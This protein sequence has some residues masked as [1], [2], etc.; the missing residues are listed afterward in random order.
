MFCRN[1]APEVYPN[2]L[3]HYY[4]ILHYMQNYTVLYY[5]VIYC[6]I[7]YSTVYSKLY[8]VWYSIVY[9]TSITIQYNTVL[10]YTILYY[11]NALHYVMLYYTALYFKVYA[12]LLLVTL[13]MTKRP[14]R[15]RGGKQ[16]HN[17]TFRTVYIVE[18]EFQDPPCTLK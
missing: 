16:P 4:T 3:D 12:I 13:G 6:S 5:T 10:Y 14:I 7:L 11:T 17:V 15:R 18:G 8:T 9:L 1:W 2:V